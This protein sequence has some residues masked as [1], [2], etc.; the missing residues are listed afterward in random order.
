MITGIKMKK[1][2]ETNM[3]PNT[4]NTKQATHL[5]AMKI[6]ANNICD[7]IEEVHR[8]DKFD[9]EFDIGLTSECKYDEDSSENEEDSS[10]KS[11][12]EE[13]IEL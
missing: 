2:D 8:R 9:K 6:N 3:I 4:C 10:G 12:N 13:G 11:N 1:I 7:I 5:G